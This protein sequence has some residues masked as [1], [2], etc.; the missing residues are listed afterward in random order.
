MSDDNNFDPR[1]YPEL[2]GDDD[3]NPLEMALL[4]EMLGS[5]PETPI[6]PSSTTN[7]NQ[8]H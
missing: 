3:L 5:N 4:M 1:Q 7:L 8:S 2:F 6:Q